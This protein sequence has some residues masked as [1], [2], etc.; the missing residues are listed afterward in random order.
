MGG[1]LELQGGLRPMWRAFLMGPGPELVKISNLWGEVV[2]PTE[3]LR[4]PTQ[5]Q[6]ITAW[7]YQQTQTG[8]LRSNFFEPQA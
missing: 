1:C 7:V 6:N 8:S 2:F 4:L 3:I 5:T